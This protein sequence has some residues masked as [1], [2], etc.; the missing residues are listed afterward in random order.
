MIVSW[1]PTEYKPRL[2][3]NY[4]NAHEMSS[5]SNNRKLI[6]EFTNMEVISDFDKSVFSGVEEIINM[7]EETLKRE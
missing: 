6:F 5:K 7:I 4:S 3:S 1:K 2:L